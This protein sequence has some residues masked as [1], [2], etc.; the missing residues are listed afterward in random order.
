M[1]SFGVSGKAD[2]SLPRAA[3]FAAGR[4]VWPLVVNGHGFAAAWRRSRRGVVEPFGGK[5]VEPDAGRE[6]AVAPDGGAMASRGGQAVP[7]TLRVS[8]MSTPR[9]S[10]DSG[11]STD[12]MEI[13]A[14][15][16]WRKLPVTRSGARW[17]TTQR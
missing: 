1:F 3:L 12:S 14:R 8:I 10:L 5:R 11:R 13:H 9:P 6:I 2:P 17:A 16:A 7:S 4:R 15:F